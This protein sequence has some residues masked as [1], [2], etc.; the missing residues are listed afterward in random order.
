ML[1]PSRW[2]QLFGGG[3][4]GRTPSSLFLIVITF[5]IPHYFIGILG[6]SGA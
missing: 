4:A 2:H 1:Q 6:H 3:E 5:N